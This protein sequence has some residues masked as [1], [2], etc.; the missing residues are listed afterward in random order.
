MKIFWEKLQ[1][2]NIRFIIRYSLIVISF[3][4]LHQSNI[5]GQNQKSFLLKPSSKY[6]IGTT[7][8]FLTDSSRKEPIKRSYKGYRRIYVKAWYPSDMKDKLNYDKY[9]SDYKT[10]T[11]FSIFKTK[12]LSLNTIDSIK[13]YYTHSCRG[14]PISNS[15]NNFPVIIFNSG[16]YFGMTDLY[17]N[18]MELL[19]SNGYIVFSIVHPYQQP[20]VKFPDGKAKLLKKKAQLAF[21]QWWVIKNHIKL[22]KITNNDI[23]KKYTYKV[24]KRLKLFDKITRLWTKDNRFFISSLKGLNADTNSIFY[25]KLNLDKIGAIG[26]SIGGATV[27]QLILSDDRIKAGIN[28]D[29]FQFGDMIDQNLQKPFMLIESQYQKKWNI[30]NQY[31]FSNDKTD[32]YSLLLLNTSHFIVTD[33]P[34]IPL[35]SDKQKEIFYG[36]VDGIYFTKLVNNYILDFFNLYLKDISSETLK[37]EISNDKIIYKIR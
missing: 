33:A 29:C 16:F 23:L 3:I 17:S 14:I 7:K 24:L 27:G 35:L 31:I 9:L 11:I 34:L 1:K 5:I 21:L 32:F 18:F 36:N 20:L 8:L 12:G 2:K 4:V 37:K 19:A 28:M 26:Q 25:S 6:S 13:Q 22:E 10:Q 30:G 15:Q